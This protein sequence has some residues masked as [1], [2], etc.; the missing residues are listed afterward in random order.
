MIQGRWPTG[1]RIDGPHSPFNSRDAIKP[2]RISQI[3]VT[4]ERKD[5][6]FLGI[7]TIERRERYGLDNANEQGT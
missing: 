1:G 5:S 7:L 2:V 4:K 6:V 3:S